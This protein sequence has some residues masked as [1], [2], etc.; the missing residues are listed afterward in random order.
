[1]H[2]SG[3]SDVCAKQPPF[4]LPLECRAVACKHGEA[5]LMISGAAL[6]LEYKVLTFT[7]TTR[8]IFHQV[9]M[10]KKKYDY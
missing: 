4:E 9:E 3:T 8:N 7:Q 1:M 10:F 2:V 6:R 5:K